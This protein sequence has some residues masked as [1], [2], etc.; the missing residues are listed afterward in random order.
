[1]RR[2]FSYFVISS[3]A[4]YGVACA[5]ECQLERHQATLQGIIV[6]SAY[7]RTPYT[8]LV[9]EHPACDEQTMVEVDVSKKWL[10]HHV[11][12][13]GGLGIMADREWFSIDIKSI[14]DSP[15]PPH[16]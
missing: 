13:V 2:I 16:D 15:Y 4:F 10:G 9:V 14:N 3:F 11:V 7:G 8:A 12:I 6:Q 5:E 1:M